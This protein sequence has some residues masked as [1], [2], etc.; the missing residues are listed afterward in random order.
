MKL[1]P[2]SQSAAIV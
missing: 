2:G 1:R